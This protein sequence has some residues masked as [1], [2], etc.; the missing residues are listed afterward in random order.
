MSFFTKNDDDR[1]SGWNS[2]KKITIE[3][4]MN[5]HRSEGRFVV[6]RL[7]CL[8]EDEG[9]SFVEGHVDSMEEGEELIKKLTKD[10]YFSRGNFRI[11]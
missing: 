3:V 6:M 7:P 8:P 2:L 5:A 11:Y 9:R 10:G 1:D 4:P